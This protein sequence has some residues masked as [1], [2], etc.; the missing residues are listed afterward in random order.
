MPISRPSRPM[1]LLLAFAALAAMAAA[2]IWGPSSWRRHIAELLPST[3]VIQLSAWKHGVAVDHT[4]SMTTTDGTRLALSLYQ[5]RGASDALP[6]IL[7]MSPY[8]RT[9]YAESY[10]TALFFA[11]NGYAAVV[12]DL[13]GTGDSEGELLPWAHVASDTSD[14]IGWIAGRP[15]SDGTVGTIGCSALGETQLVA[16]GAAPAEWRAAIP[17][18]AGGAVGEL[19]GRHAYFGLFEG[20]VFQLASGFGWFVAS[21][22]KR[23]DA[24]PARAFE[25]AS[26]LREL[27]IAD[28]V[29]R[30]RPAPSG[31]SDFLETPL[32][33]PKWAEWGYLD[34]D[35]RMRVPSLLVSSWGDQTLSETL[36]IAEHWRRSDPQGT[37]G[38]L[39]TII[40]PGSHCRY[41]ET[42]NT[43][44]FGEMRVA[45]GGL[46]Y[47]D[48]YLRW[49]DYWLRGR[50]DAL[51]D[52]PA[53]TFHVLGADAWLES[54]TWPPED[55]ERQ[56]WWL[57]SDGRSNSREGDGRLTR[58]PRPGAA[59]DV[60]RYDPAD[61]VPSV[62]G[63]ICCTGDPDEV[64][65]PADQ[66][67]VERRDDVLV[68]T[69][70]P[71]EEDLWIAGPL[72]LHVQVSSDA[73]DTDLVARLVDV[74]PDGRALG[75][76]EGALRLRY[77]D[78]VAA[79]QLLRPGERVTATVEMRDIAYRFP[80]GHR[81]RLHLTSSSFPRLERNLNTGG[82]NARET[83]M[84][85][86][87]NRVHYDQ[88]EAGSWLELWAAP[89]R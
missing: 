89:G 11:R 80:K 19:A 9:R 26:M 54:E 15:W 1:A 5:P 49:F 86:A 45:N 48:L 13:R 65:G 21:G 57:G 63:P 14:V 74:A 61:P 71:L 43:G 35:S 38:R 44:R 27:P 83:N 78:G 73:P 52:M 39:K 82:D 17:I 51:A 70:P 18:G 10:S 24:P 47:N 68:Y 46:A 7:I 33:D 87:T 37:D 58:E 75:I 64:M 76:Q 4:L 16:Q 23:P 32:G 41:L 3:W 30:V 42:M 31:Y 36:L 62:G 88:P 60:W 20:G 2:V 53:Y 6:T 40:A 81:L 12:L 59:S 72:R 56:R 55:A 22:S 8:H 79:P 69:S 28:L 77:R 34:D 25:P 85:V 50:G 67:E 29:S 84:A 66:A